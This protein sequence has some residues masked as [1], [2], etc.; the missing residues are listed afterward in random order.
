MQILV[1]MKLLGLHKSSLLDAVPCK[2]KQCKEQWQQRKLSEA[3][4]SAQV[5]VQERGLDGAWKAKACTSRLHPY[6]YV[7]T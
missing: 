7:W 1:V 4:A 3:A 5:L 2:L 6:C